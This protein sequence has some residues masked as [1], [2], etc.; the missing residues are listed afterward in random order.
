L[1]R[2]VGVVYRPDT[3]KASHY[4]QSQ[5][6]KEFDSVIFL[7]ET[8]AVEP[9]DETAPWKR[10]HEMIES[11]KDSDEFP[12]LESGVH[13]PDELLDWRI[14]AAT[15]INDIG[16]SLMQKKDLHSAL[17]K[18]DKAIKYVEHSLQK[19]QSN[20]NL[21]EIRAEVLVNRAEVNSQ[22]KSWTQ[23]IRD[24]NTVLALK[25]TNLQAH[26]LVAKAHSERGNTR[27]AQFH[28]DM[29]A[30]TTAEEPMKFKKSRTVDDRK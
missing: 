7:D 20:R 29:A 26:L 25:P 13:M 14:E 2:Y 21:Q 18:F 3:E 8:S 24:C 28:F 27:E 15:K 9:I 4:C 12:E 30:K 22:F 11:V 1:E 6:V 17:A 10:E 19:F 16:C 5:I 23:V